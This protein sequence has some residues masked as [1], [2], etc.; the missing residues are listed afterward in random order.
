MQL[1]QPQQN[2]PSTPTA[3]HPHY[4]DTQGNPTT[5]STPTH[6]PAR[7]HTEK[8]NKRAHPA[9]LIGLLI[10]NKVYLT[11]TRPVPLPAL[12]G[13]Q[14]RSLALYQHPHK[15]TA[16]KGKHNDNHQNHHPKHSTPTPHQTGTRKTTHNATA[17][18]RI[19]SENERPHPR[20]HR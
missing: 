14:G 11:T 1:L 10:H 3:T 12:A 9:T 17:K 15:K 2:Q 5:T 20:R 8:T 7:K 13:V 18:T 16:Q 6:H 4:Q 19:A